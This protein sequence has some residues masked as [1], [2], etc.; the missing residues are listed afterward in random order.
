MT[1][2][3]QVS[4]VSSLPLRDGFRRLHDAL[5][6]VFASIR[7][8]D[9]DYGALSDHEV[10]DMARDTCSFIKNVTSDF[11]RREMFPEVH[12]DTKHPPVVTAELTGPECLASV[13]WIDEGLRRTAD[14]LRA[15]AQGLLR[16]FP[17]HEL[18]LIDAMIVDML[19]GYLLEELQ[20]LEKTHRL[21]SRPR[22]QT[23]E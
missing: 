17:D 10:D 23:H 14:A 8:V 11:I 13:P 3:Q 12:D 9:G 4:S 19:E 20:S 7:T 1:S 2:Q 21:S 15:I 5:W 22:R 16:M 6:D 18:M